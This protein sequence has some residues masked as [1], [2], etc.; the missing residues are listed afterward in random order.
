[1]AGGTRFPQELE[2]DHV[3]ELSSILHADIDRI[4]WFAPLGSEGDAIRDQIDSIAYRISENS[5]LEAAKLI[6]AIA[7]YAAFEVLAIHERSPELF[8]QIAPF[9]LLMPTLVSVHPKSSNVAKR[10][11]LDGELGTKTPESIHIG[12]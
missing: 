4:L 5:D 9:R 1:G 3:S 7:T 12:S 2:T 8:K 11:R 10:M 6:Y